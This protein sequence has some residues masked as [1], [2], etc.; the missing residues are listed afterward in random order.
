MAKANRPTTL[1]AVKA[2]SAKSGKFK[3]SD[4]KLGAIYKEDEFRTIVSAL[5]DGITDRSLVKSANDV[6]SLMNYY[7]IDATANPVYDARSKYTGNVRVN[8]VLEQSDLFD[9]KYNKSINGY[10][11]D[12]NA[13]T[14][15]RGFGLAKEELKE[16]GYY[17]RSVTRNGV[18]YD[19]VITKKRKTAN[20]RTRYEIVK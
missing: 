15:H 7:T 13:R 18:T 16:A 11:L 3:L 2:K 14:Y 6:A 9:A 20:G 8:Y 19:N 4:L 17:L 10:V 5:S 1:V 12:N